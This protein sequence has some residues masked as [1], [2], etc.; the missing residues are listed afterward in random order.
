MGILQFEKTTKA[1]RTEACREKTNIPNLVT[2]ECT[3]P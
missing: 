1:K 2:R 3:Y